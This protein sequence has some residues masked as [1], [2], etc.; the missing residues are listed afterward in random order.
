MV[1]LLALLN[2]AEA[3]LAQDDPILRI[4]RAGYDCERMVCGVKGTAG[5]IGRA[6]DKH[7]CA[8]RGCD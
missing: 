7:R 3:A 6:P 8:S 2:T 4:G 5:L 1:D